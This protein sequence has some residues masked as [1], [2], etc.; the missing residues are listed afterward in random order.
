MIAKP[1]YPLSRDNE[2][3]LMKNLHE[4]KFKAFNI[5]NL[6]NA[7][8]ETGTRVIFRNKWIFFAK[9]IS[10]MVNIRNTKKLAKLSFN[11][12]KLISCRIFKTLG[13]WSKRAKWKKLVR[14]AVQLSTK[15]SLH[16]C[17]P[18]I[19]THKTEVRRKKWVNFA[20][21]VK[22]KLQNEDLMEESDQ[23]NK[24][25]LLRKLF[26]FWN[27]EYHDKLTSRSNKS[28]KWNVITDAILLRYRLEEIKK[29]FIRLQRHH[30]WSTWSNEMIFLNYRNRLISGRKEIE[31]KNLLIDF[32]DRYTKLVRTRTLKS[33]QSLYINRCKWLRI[34]DNYSSFTQKDNLLK[35]KSRMCMKIRYQ[36][37]SNHL[38]HVNLINDCIKAKSD[39]DNKT[40]ED[41]EKETQRYFITLWL[42]RAMYKKYSKEYLVSLYNDSYSSYISHLT[43]S[44]ALLIQD[45]YR[46]YSDRI[47]R[48]RAILRNSFNVW[49]R[50]QK[51][52]VS[53]MVVI[54]QVSHAISSPL[55]FSIDVFTKCIDVCS[56]D[57]TSDIVSYNKRIKGGLIDDV[58]KRSLS[59]IN[60]LF[61]WSGLLKSV[62]YP[63]CECEASSAISETIDSLQDMYLDSL[64]FNY[65]I[66]FHDSLISLS[67]NLNNHAKSVLHLSFS[68]KPD[69]DEKLVTYISER[70]FEDE[71]LMIPN[72]TR[73]NVKSLNSLFK[74]PG[75]N[76]MSGYNSDLYNEYDIIPDFELPDQLRNIARISKIEIPCYIDFIH[77]LS[78]T[79]T[80]SGAI[81]ELSRQVVKKF[82]SLLDILINEKKECVVEDDFEIEAVKWFNLDILGTLE[83]LSTNSNVFL[84]TESVPLI[85]YDKSIESDVAEMFDLETIYCKLPLQGLE[86]IAQISKID[87]SIENSTYIDEE[88][89]DSAIMC[90]ISDRTFPVS[91]KSLELF[92][93]GDLEESYSQIGWEPSF[94]F[95]EIEMCDIQ[96]LLNMCPI[97]CSDADTDFMKRLM[98]SR[99]ILD[100]SPYVHILCDKLNMINP[101]DVVT[102]KTLDQISHVPWDLTPDSWSLLLV[103]NIIRN[104]NVENAILDFIPLEPVKE[105]DSRDDLCIADNI[106][107]DISFDFTEITDVYNTIYRSASELDISFLC[108]HEVINVC[109]PQFLGDY[110]EVI[111]KINMFKHIPIPEDLIYS[112]QFTLDDIRVPTFDSFVGL[113]NSIE[114]PD[115]NTMIDNLDCYAKI[116]DVLLDLRYT[117]QLYKHIRLSGDGTT[118]QDYHEGIHLIYLINSVVSP[119]FSYEYFGYQSER[120]EPKDIGLDEVLYQSIYRAFHADVSASHK[121]LEAHGPRCET[122]DAYLDY[123]LESAVRSIVFTKENIHECNIIECMFDIVSNQVMCKLEQQSDASIEMDD[124]SN[125][126]TSNTAARSLIDGATAASESLNYD[127]EDTKT[128]SMVDDIIE[129]MFNNVFDKFGISH[130]VVQEKI[131]LQ[132]LDI[133]YISE[134]LAEP[135]RFLVSSNMELI[136]ENIDICYITNE[137]KSLTKRSTASGHA[138]SRANIRELCDSF[139]ISIAEATEINIIHPIMQTVNQLFYDGLEEALLELKLQ[140]GRDAI[141]KETDLLKDNNYFY[142]YF[143][144][145]FTESVRSSVAISVLLTYDMIYDLNTCTSNVKSRLKRDKKRRD[146]SLYKR[147][148]E[149]YLNTALLC[150]LS[151]ALTGARHAESRS[152]G[153][154]CVPHILNDFGTLIVSAIDDLVGEVLNKLM[155]I[156]IDG[157]DV[158][159]GGSS[160]ISNESNVDF[161]DE[162][163]FSSLF[164]ETLNDVVLHALSKDKHTSS[165]EKDELSVDGSSDISAGGLGIREE[166]GKILDASC[167]NTINS[168]MRSTGVDDSRSEVLI[169]EHLGH[170]IS[171]TLHAIA[172]H[173][174]NIVL[175]SLMLDAEDLNRSSSH[176][177]EPFDSE[178]NMIFQDVINQELSRVVS[179]CI[180][181]N[182]LVLD[183]ELMVSSAM[184]EDGW[185]VSSI[186]NKRDRVSDYAL[187]VDFFDSYMDTVLA[188]YVSSILFNSAYCTPLI[189]I[190]SSKR[191]KKIKSKSKDELRAFGINLKRI[192]KDLVHRNICNLLSTDIPSDE[193]RQLEISNIRSD[194][195][196]R[197]EISAI[198]PNHISF[199]TKM[200][201]EIGH[202]DASSYSENSPIHKSYVIRMSKE[203]DNAL[204]N[205]LNVALTKEGLSFESSISIIEKYEADAKEN[206][207]N[208]FSDFSKS[209]DYVIQ[210]VCVGAILAN[211]ADLGVLFFETKLKDTVTSSESQIPY[212]SNSSVSK[213]NLNVERVVIHYCEEIIRRSVFSVIESQLFDA[214]ESKI[215]SS[216]LESKDST[217]IEYL[218]ES[219]DMS[220]NEVC[221]YV[222]KDIC[223]K[224]DD[225]FGAHSEHI[226]SEIYESNV[227]F[228]Q[229]EAFRK[230]LDIAASIICNGDTLHTPGFVIGSLV[231]DGETITNE[232]PGAV[233]IQEQGTQGEGSIQEGYAHEEIRILLNRCLWD[234]IKSFCSLAVIQ[235]VETPSVIGLAKSKI[236]KMKKSAKAKRKEAG[237]L[238]NARDAVINVGNQMLEHNSSVLK[239]DYKHSLNE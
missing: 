27:N 41:G 142:S 153:A 221:S 110:S 155:N 115:S 116:Q 114:Y 74:I 178:L 237:E 239:D 202:D 195:S 159:T 71:N 79:N 119:L 138:F 109:V 143:Y 72:I 62:V 190:I 37:F 156:K 196:L 129:G 102:C 228:D 85:I 152:D 209:F 14:L 29:A 26:Y 47:S 193:S 232:S 206:M 65:N 121:D 24:E 94:G 212:P 207:I 70:S 63:L 30:R 167:M 108:E 123:A 49:K 145:S 7:F 69:I 194:L 177:N 219:L 144:K 218:R 125:S 188:S 172:T 162:T 93:G 117:T 56:L 73:L 9:K 17:M 131:D 103:G 226:R 81:P 133:T 91:I 182:M 200:V 22:R 50:T 210:D 139:E 75:T 169:Y 130:L 201:S 236:L 60:I 185:K 46:K 158:E 132:M 120:I 128:C 186:E 150:A 118:L 157:I 164:E 112:I 99:L 154:S 23:I 97:Q 198:K 231:C 227:Q 105:Y 135:V 214:D 166:L 12:D 146:I 61:P 204:N 171:E 10:T 86:S 148:F 1:V 161:F 238:E 165:Q 224:L 57:N 33:A 77:E 107:Y 28:V 89:I 18:E 6:V 31:Y 83:Q 189:E 64:T 51:E 39:F 76:K 92:P 20:L 176:E 2:D 40:R 149:S 160:L 179:V 174:I 84:R 230:S 96:P 68:S 222:V 199:T 235:S 32:Y 104:S 25:K 192:L 42:E 11:Y 181:R 19:Q 13:F 15:E 54:P 52:L 151:T 21:N 203:L 8:R 45:F 208:K 98:N 205:A 3:S 180:N 183:E 100:I 48:R 234:S 5:T 87:S 184:K 141:I 58:S 213:V 127:T 216:D 187:V 170:D 44:S 101:N 191:R 113:S 67:T 95:E 225:L 43:N 134:S 223:M 229:I 122:I 126:G 163:Y 78:D 111:D 168:I 137:D 82:G 173:S 36:E 197:N 90:S 66:G 136:L 4:S 80:L 217:N 106:G 140:S 211:L 233:L 220:L 175:E 35:G 34:I 53:K 147:K 16:K 38:L 59:A 88:Y 124:I 215:M 55:D